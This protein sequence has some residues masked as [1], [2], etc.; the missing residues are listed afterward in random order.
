[1]TTTFL[2]VLFSFFFFPP[3]IRTD[4]I[5][6]VA[7][8]REHCIQL[9]ACVLSSFCVTYLMP[10]ATQWRSFFLSLP[11]PLLLL[12][13]L[14]LFLARMYSDPGVEE[15][16]EKNC[17]ITI[18]QCA[19]KSSQVRLFLLAW[20]LPLDMLEKRRKKERER[21]CIERQSIKVQRYND[22][23]S[24]RERKGDRKSERNA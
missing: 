22:L 9:C 16:R 24:K 19:R 6:I 18:G 10:T 21:K 4:C 15:R 3:Q 11:P 1:M 2:S 12:L 14:S 7:L 23:K 5:Q 13:L 17:E 8:H 20:Q